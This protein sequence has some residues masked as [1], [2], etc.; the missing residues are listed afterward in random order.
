MP[1]KNSANH[2]HRYKKV[3]LAVYGHIPYFVYKCTKP[4]CSHYIPMTLAEGKLCECNR[5]GELMIISKQVMS[6][7]SGN[8]MTLPHCG[9]CTKKR[10]V[11]NVTAITEFLEGTKT[12][13]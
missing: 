5:C 1:S 3:N 9:E 13:I 12:K 8:P 6:Q 2:I 4:A 7:S 10:K 11:V